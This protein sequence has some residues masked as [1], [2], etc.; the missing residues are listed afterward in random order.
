MKELRATLKSDRIDEQG[1]EDRLDAAVDL[2]AELANHDADQQRSRNAAKHEVADF[3]FSDEV[4]ECD[5]EKEREQGLCREQSVQQVHVS[6]S[7]SIVRAA[8]G[9]WQIADPAQEDFANHRCSPGRGE[10]AS[11]QSSV[12]VPSK[13]L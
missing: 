3:Q 13:V 12:I 4:A 1:K 2:D 7:M 6:L 5:G 11:S 8:A 9:C 10:I